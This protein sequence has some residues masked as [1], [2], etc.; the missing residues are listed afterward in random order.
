M[1]RAIKR[2]AIVLAAW[3]PFFAIWVFFAML[4]AHYPLRAALMTSLIS[5]GTASLLAI[6]AWHVC[7]RWPWPLRLDLKFYLLQIFFASLYSILWSISVYGLESIRRGAGP[8]PGFWRSPF[9]GW[10]LLMGVW[11]YGLFAG[12]SYAV[13]T[14]NRLH[15]KE[16]LAV[17]AEALAAAARLDALRARLNPH[18]LFNA[19]HTLAA[20]V[21]FR[22]TMAEGAIERLGDMLRYTLR[23]DGRELVEFSE[24][25]D[26]TRQYVAFEQLRYED[27]LKVDLQID[28]ESFNFEILPFSMQTLAENAVRHAISIRP[29]GGSIWIKCSHHDGRLTLSVR[30]DGPGG[31]SDAGQSHQF[32]LRSLRERLRAAYGPSADLR[33]HSG[34]EGFEASFVVPPSSE[35]PLVERERAGEHE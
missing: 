15:E 8:S 3:L 5:M 26:F 27:R 1:P 32:G 7:Q 13:Q 29:E 21:K 6:P 25:Y 35:S 34:P 17:R 18:F 2:Y 30:D 28:P 12:V 22:P 4:Y 11:L 19:L 14:R 24:E 20:L 33:V 31:G 9:L 10:Q 23:E 16:T